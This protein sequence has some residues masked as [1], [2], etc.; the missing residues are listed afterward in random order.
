[1]KE[2]IKLAPEATAVRIDCQAGEW[3]GE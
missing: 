1:V 2:K 3:P